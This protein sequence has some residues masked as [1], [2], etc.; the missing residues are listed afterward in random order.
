M[1]KLGIRGKLVKRHFSTIQGNANSDCELVK[2]KM[3]GIGLKQ[4]VKVHNAL[5]YNNLPKLTDSI[6]SQR[7]VDNYSHLQ[8]IQ[9]PNLNDNCISMIIGIGEVDAHCVLQCK[10][11]PAGTPLAIKS[12]LGWSIGGP[13]THYSGHVAEIDAV[14]YVG[15]INDRSACNR[16]NDL[17]I[18]LQKTYNEEFNELHS[19]KIATSI[20]D[21]IAVGI[22]KKSIVRI[23]NK[24]HVPLP[25]RA[26]YGMLPDNRE[27][28]KQYLKRMIPKFKKDPKLFEWYDGQIKMYL[29]E[30]RG[31][32]VL[33]QRVNCVRDWKLGTLYISN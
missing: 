23:D 15:L 3:K 2:F 7:D 17:D 25:L 33:Y 20:E 19:D 16:D 4:V 21:D 28:A 10:K 6:P 8:G 12:V 11:G 31:A 29:E 9:F 13:D 14:N 30:G 5:T 18:L 24:Y 26:D 1:K 22:V 27:H 32:Q